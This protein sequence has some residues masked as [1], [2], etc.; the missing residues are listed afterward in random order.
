MIRRFFSKQRVNDYLIIF[1]IAFVGL[2]IRLSLFREFNINLHL[3]AFGISIFLLP[4]GYEL[5]TGINRILNKYL[6][7]EDGPVLRIALQLILS[8]A[9]ISLIVFQIYFIVSDKIPFTINRYGYFLLF[10]FYF[11]LTL[12][13]NAL[14]FARYFFNRMKQSIIN[15]QMLER[16]KTQVQYQNLLNQLNPHFFFNSLTSLNSLIFKD[17]QLAS[18]F[19]QQLSRIYRYMLENK[20]KELV[21]L[22]AEIDFVKQYIE[23]L[24]TRFGNGLVFKI[25]IGNEW[26]DKL[27]VPVSLQIMIENALKHNVIDQ[28]SPLKIDIYTSGA[29]LCIDNNIQ[30]KKNIEHSHKLGLESFKQ[31]Y[32]YLSPSGPV[33]AE[34]CEG[35]F[36]VK[37]PLL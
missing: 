7:Y 36:K 14:Y 20:D 18:D 34:A 24:K 26:L 35:M 6:P 4:L 15:Q 5:I 19:L 13:F 16:E 17:Q 32:N 11:V 27:I 8:F 2:I 10:S 12:A 29:W 30:Q 9:L 33:I 31:L 3:L 1:A 22:G 28:D 37:I 23:L 21:T 25:S